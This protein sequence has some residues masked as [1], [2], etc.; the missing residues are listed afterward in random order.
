ML[1]AGEA[2]VV[3]KEQ[4]VRDTIIPGIVDSGKQPA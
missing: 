4:F 1:T 2:L 3:D